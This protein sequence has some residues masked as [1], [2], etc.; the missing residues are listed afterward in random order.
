MFESWKAEK[1]DAKE[2]KLINKQKEKKPPTN[3]GKF[4]VMVYLIIFTGLI[5]LGD[6]L[7]KACQKR[8]DSLDSN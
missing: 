4:F 2:A 6:L 3:F 7:K 5:P 8:Q 1:K